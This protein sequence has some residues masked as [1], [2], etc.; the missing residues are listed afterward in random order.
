MVTPL[1]DSGDGI[2]T[3]SVRHLVDFLIEGGI[4]GLFPLGTSGE[5]ALLSDEERESM[6]KETIDRANGRVPVLA[7]V[8][9]TSIER[10][11]M[12]S[13]QAKDLGADAVI[14]TPPYYYKAGPD[15]LYEYY[16]QLSGSI[17]IPLF[18]YNIPDWVGYIVPVEVIKK[19]AGEG[20]IAGMKYT[21]YNFL[22]L[23]DF[24]ETCGSQIAVFTG[25]DSLAYSI[26]EFGGKGA[27]IAV[28]NLAPTVASS[29][30][31][32]HIRKDFRAAREAQTHLIQLIKAVSMGRFPSG[33]KETMNLLGLN[34][35]PVKQP[36]P[37]LNENEKLVVRNLLTAS[38]MIKLTA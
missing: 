9:D 15:N 34:V 25:E 21:D 6:L 32:H 22:N 33:L 7:G 23:L 29:I 35:G 38:K 19:L 13:K 30:Y 26:L 4:D 28:A 14:S 27:I 24:I 16:R 17:D 10:V 12:F 3:E 18:I 37:P 36:L 5:F 20:L 1:N 31:D 2:N 8:S 11:I